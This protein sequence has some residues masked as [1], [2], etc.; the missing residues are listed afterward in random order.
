MRHN[1]LYNVE[2]SILNVAP[3]F[4]ESI[5]MQIILTET[6]L[7]AYP[8][9]LGN[10]NIQIDWYDRHCFSLYSDSSELISKANSG[11]PEDNVV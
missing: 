11:W 1:V 4:G 5:K 3:S 7:G 2:K 8:F 10:P 9:Y 6:L